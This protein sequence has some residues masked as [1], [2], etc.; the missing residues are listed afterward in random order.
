MDKKLYLYPNNLN[1][2]FINNQQKLSLDTFKVEKHVIG[3]VA[4]MLFKKQ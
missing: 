3:Q 1:F 4:D 2:D